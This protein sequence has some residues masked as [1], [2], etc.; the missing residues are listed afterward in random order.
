M[1]V[2]YLS[3]EYFTH[4]MSIEYQFDEDLDQDLLDHTL[5]GGIRIIQ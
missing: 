5:N 4:R 1:K 2:I 3:G